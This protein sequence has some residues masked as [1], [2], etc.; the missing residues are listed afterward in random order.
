MLNRILFLFKK[1]KIIRAWKKNNN[2]NK[3]TL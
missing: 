2:N 3:T 1:I